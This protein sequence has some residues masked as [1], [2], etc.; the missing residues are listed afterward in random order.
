VTVGFE[1][2]RGLRAINQTMD[3][4]TVSVSKTIDR[5]VE[6]LYR[7]IVDDAERDRW[8]PPGT[9]R[10]RTATPHRTARFDFGDGTSR[11]AVGFTAKG[12]DR[13]MMA[14]QHDHLAGPGDVERMRTFWRTAFVELVAALAHS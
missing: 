8:L 4:F 11:V 1:R 9:L 14:L 6:A 7:A 13:A 5:P 12:P 10:V 3:G 2:A